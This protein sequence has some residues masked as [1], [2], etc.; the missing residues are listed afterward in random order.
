MTAY[1]GSFRDLDS[2]SVNV[3]ANTSG[4]ISG[5]A[6][7]PEEAVTLG[8]VTGSTFT[9]TTSD[10]VNF[11]GSIV[12]GQSISRS[13]TTTEGNAGTFSGTVCTLP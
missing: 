1:C 7:G 11:T 9:G 10:Q 8:Q 4:A 13:Y 5:I 2:G 6:V 3:I 12:A